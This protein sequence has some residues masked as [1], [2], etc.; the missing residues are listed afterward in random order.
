MI[1][2]CECFRSLDRTVVKP[3]V[4]SALS[5]WPLTGVLLR[6]GQ[7]EPVEKHITC[8][9]YNDKSC[10]CHTRPHLH[11][12]THTNK[13]LFDS[14]IYCK[15]IWEYIEN[16]LKWSSDQD[17]TRCNSSQP[18]CAMTFCNKLELGN[19]SLDCA[20]NVVMVMDALNKSTARSIRLPFSD[21][22]QASV[23]FL[24]FSS[25]F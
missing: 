9:T 21:V 18:M 8:I 3:F 19:D 24:F 4:F 20:V 5:L 11:T 6:T 14:T 22:N 1:I 25:L 13:S 2:C 12:H 16:R 17:W 23:F 15:E 7:Y 10:P